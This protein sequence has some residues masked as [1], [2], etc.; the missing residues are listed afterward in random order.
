MSLNIFDESR[1][2][3]DNSTRFKAGIMHLNKITRMVT[4]DTRKGYIH[5]KKDE[6][7]YAEFMWTERT[8]TKPE[9]KFLLLPGDAEYKH[10]KEARNGRVYLLDIKSV[11][12][13]HFFWMQE[14][15]TKYDEKYANRINSI[16]NG[17]DIEDFDFKTKTLSKDDILNIIKS[18]DLISWLRHFTDEDSE[19]DMDSEEDSSQGEEMMDY[20]QTEDGNETHLIELLLENIPEEEHKTAMEVILSTQYFDT[21]DTLEEAHSNGNLETMLKSFHIE[22]PSGVGGSEKI[23]EFLMKVQKKLNEDKGEKEEGVEEKG[24]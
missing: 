15:S 7:G 20:D 19:G 13:K 21:I 10:V 3:D 2:N 12:E 6:D 9:L 16:V 17:S 1:S 14:Q 5:V 18:D 8:S 11:G 24:L 22:I 4:A 23:E